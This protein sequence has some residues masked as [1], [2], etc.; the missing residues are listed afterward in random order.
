MPGAGHVTGGEEGRGRQGFDS[1][2]IF[3][4][5]VYSG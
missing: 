5:W 4:S 2:P 3:A 1:S